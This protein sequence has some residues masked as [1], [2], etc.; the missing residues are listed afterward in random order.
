MGRADPPQAITGFFSFSSDPSVVPSAIPKSQTLSL[1]LSHQIDQSPD[2]H[3]RISRTQPPDSISR[4]PIVPPSILEPRFTSR[5]ALSRSES[6]FGF[7]LLLDDPVPLDFVGINW[8]LM[9]ATTD[10][11]K[12]S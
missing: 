6:F 10:R 3:R 8:I 2:R 5:F 11:G 7:V 4:L 1:S 9:R 12:E